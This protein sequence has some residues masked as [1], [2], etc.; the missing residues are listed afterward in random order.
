MLPVLIAKV[1][2]PLPEWLKAAHGLRDRA[3]ALLAEHFPA[4]RAELEDARRRLVFDEFFRIGLA[5]L[6]MSGLQ[7]SGS[8]VRAVPHGPLVRRFLGQ[9]RFALTGGGQAAWE[10]IPGAPA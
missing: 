2:D 1:V 10:E 9:L 3:W 4:D 6:W 8:G 7:Q 5:V